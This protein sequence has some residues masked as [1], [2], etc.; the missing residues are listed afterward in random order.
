MTID[1]DVVQQQDSATSNAII[2]L[3]E[4]DA[5]FLRVAEKE[6]AAI[7]QR[8]DEDDEKLAQ[9]I[10]IGIDKGVLKADIEVEPTHQIDVLGK[11]ADQ[12]ADEV[13]SKLGTSDEGKVIVFHGLSG[14][15]KGTTVAKL[16]EKLTNV[17]TWS[18]GNIFRSLTLLAVTYCEDRG[19]EFSPDALTPDVLASLTKMLEFGKFDDKFDT[20]IE[21]LGLKYFVSE[22]QNTVLKEQ[23]IGSNI[24]TVAKLTQGEVVSFA[25]KAVA[26][27]GAAGFNVL[28]EGREATLNYVRSPYR[29]ELTLSDKQLIGKRRLAQKV[30]AAALKK[31]GD[32]GE[33]E[34]ELRAAVSDIAKECDQQQ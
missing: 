4:A 25:D 8:D 18:N 7:M 31:Q 28:M 17:V 6:T 30:G 1:W 23:R 20:K 22:V 32:G 9:G 15:G 26:Q 16:K 2:Q 34:A 24:P 21:G 29:F 3:F 13:V 33:A 5:I 12:V 10:K 11:S 14:T 27:M 19:I